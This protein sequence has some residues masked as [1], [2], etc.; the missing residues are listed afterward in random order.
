MASSAYVDTLA[1]TEP[2]LLTV[3]QEAVLDTDAVVMPNALEG[4]SL[5][6][7]PV[8]VEDHA[9]MGGVSLALR[10]CS[11]KRGAELAEAALLPPTLSLRVQ[12]VRWG[13]YVLEEEEEA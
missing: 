5:V 11:V 4:T 3:G 7:G 6:M 2:D 8:T 13:A 9:R 10:N 1:I 12:G